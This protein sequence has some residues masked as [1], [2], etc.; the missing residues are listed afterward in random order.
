MA[1]KRLSLEDTEQMKNMVIKGVSPED[2]AKHFKV[3][4]SSVHN[5]K[6]RF[7]QQ[8]VEFP[9]VRGKRP[10]GSVDVQSAKDTKKVASTHQLTSQDSM[11]F[12]VNGVSV[13]VSANAKNVNI[14]KDTIEITF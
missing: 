1:N 2:I 8:G 6:K 11:N 14:S 12:I 10:S 3:A 4:I 5:Y 7:K 13:H 9:D